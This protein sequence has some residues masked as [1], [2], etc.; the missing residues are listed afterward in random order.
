M[1]TGRGRAGLGWN[2]PNPNPRLHPPP[3]APTMDE[4]GPALDSA[5]MCYVLLNLPNI[6]KN[7]MGTVSFTKSQGTI[8]VLEMEQYLSLSVNLRL[9]VGEAR[10]ESP[11]AA[12][13]VPSPRPRLCAATSPAASVPSP[14]P[15]LSH[16]PPQ[17]RRPL[18]SPRH[19][20]ACL[21]SPLRLVRHRR[22]LL[23]P[24]GEVEP[25]R[26]RDS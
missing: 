18:L 9:C 6:H 3:S 17:S 1:A 8:G 10:R 7:I 15:C 2:A 16:R 24:E 20:L 4:R 21:T 19:T 23:T 5:T 12:V 13:P 25:W 22:P 26:G 14:R 11:A